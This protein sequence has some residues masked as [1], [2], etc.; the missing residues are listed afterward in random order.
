VHAREGEAAVG[1]PEQVLILVVDEGGII[2]AL[3]SA[4]QLEVVKGISGDPA[5]FRLRAPPW[6]AFALISPSKPPCAYHPTSAIASQMAHG[7]K[8]WCS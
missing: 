5:A 2:P 3:L 4:L 1:Q 6:A 7:S 8:V